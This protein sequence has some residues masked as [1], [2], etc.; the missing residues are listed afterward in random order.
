MEALKIAVFKGADQFHKQI[1]KHWCHLL[2]VCFVLK[3]YNAGIVD[4]C[5][6]TVSKANSR[7]ILMNQ[8]L[9]AWRFALLYLYYPMLCL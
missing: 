1:I 7:F 8:A 3:V 9:H 4:Y 6:L 5:L 2:R